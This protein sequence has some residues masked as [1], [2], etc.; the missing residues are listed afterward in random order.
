MVVE[1]RSVYVS[2]L[3]LSRDAEAPERSGLLSSGV[4]GL[5]NVLSTAAVEEGICGDSERRPWLR[6][7]G[8]D[9]CES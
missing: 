4:G 3:A 5:E 2:S 7:C 1:R 6:R 9:K 8:N